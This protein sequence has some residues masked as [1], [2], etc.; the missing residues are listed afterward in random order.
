MFLSKNNTLLIILL[1]SSFTAISQTNN[2]PSTLPASIYQI[3]PKS[4][5]FNNKYV[6][7]NKLDLTSYKFATLDLRSFEEGYFT[8]PIFNNTPTEFMYDSYNKLYANLQLKKSFFKVADLYKV[9]D[10]NKN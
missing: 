4:P 6:I 7:N 9:R 3:V 10:K 2:K 8:I 1:T 5:N